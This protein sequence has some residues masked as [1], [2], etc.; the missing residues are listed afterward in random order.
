MPRF[1]VLADNTNHTTLPLEIQHIY[2]YDCAFLD[3]PGR[4]G[5]IAVVLAVPP[6]H[7][8][9]LPPR[10]GRHGRVQLRNRALVVDP[11]LV[12]A[13]PGKAPSIVVADDF[14]AK[15]VGTSMSDFHSTAPY[16]PRYFFTAS[17]THKRRSVHS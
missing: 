13:I 5:R 17:Q 4:S 8:R 6:R 7:R 15:R 10:R 9:A 11:A 12:A 1:R 3:T 2:P 16:S 14:S